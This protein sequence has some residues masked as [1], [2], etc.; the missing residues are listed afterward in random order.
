[1]L[2]LIVALGTMV[3]S[4][5]DSHSVG[6]PNAIWYVLFVIF[7]LPVIS[8]CRKIVRSHKDAEGI[9]EVMKQFRAYVD[10]STKQTE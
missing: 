7:I 8:S 5:F 9:E 1:M 3:S 6:N 4:S 2:V 10:S